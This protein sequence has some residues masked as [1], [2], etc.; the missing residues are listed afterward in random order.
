M[1]R[2]GNSG[3]AHQ[4]RDEDK[5]KT[6]T[7]NRKNKD[8]KDKSHVKCYNCNIYGHFSAECRIPR[9][10]KERD[11]PWGQKANLAQVS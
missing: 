1:S 7:P 3:R 10:E 5:G 9:R 2:G 4:N 8:V 6:H 11:K